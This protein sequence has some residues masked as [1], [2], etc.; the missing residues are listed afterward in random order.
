MFEIRTITAD[1]ADLFRTRVS[2]GFGGDPDTDDQAMAR[3]DALFEYDRALA[4]FDGDDIIGT[5]GAFSLGLTVPGGAEV[6][7]GG[8]TIITVQPTHRRRGVLRSLMDRHLDDVA[9][10]GEPLA[11]LWASESGIYG[12]FGY[13]AATFRNYAEVSSKSVE[14]VGEPAKGDVRLVE[15]DEAEP[16]LRSLYEQARPQRAGMLTRSDSWWQYRRMAD[17]EQWREGMTKRR[18]LI[19]EENGG[20]TGYATYRQKSKWDDFMADGKIDLTEVIATTADAH[21]GMWQFLTRVDLFP[22]VEWWNMP[23]DDPLPMKITDQRRVKRAVKDALWVRVMDIPAALSAR[24]YDQDGS[25][26]FEVN[27]A[28]RPANSGAYRLEVNGREVGCERVTETPDVSLDI[29][30]LG[31]LYLGGGD[32][33]S[34]AA[35]GRIE[36]EEAGVATLHRL[37]RSDRPPW[38]PEVF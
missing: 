8:T 13:G 11:G 21:T 6:P 15:A 31:H 3:F 29:D 9:S 7:M 37:M 2:R 28:V 18:Y 4:V 20:V 24:T 5:G 34:M 36:G 17:P 25:T 12:R 14:F 1:D 27:D 38:C 30:V 19:Y 10:R 16:I 33:F 32:A 22:N 26:V 35:A 23:L